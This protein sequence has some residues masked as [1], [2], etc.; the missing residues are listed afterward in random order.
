MIPIEKWVVKSLIYPKQLGF[1]L[2]LMTTWTLLYLFQGP[3]CLRCGCSWWS[4]VRMLSSDSFEHLG[5]N[6]SEKVAKSLYISQLTVLIGS[7]WWFQPNRKIWSSKSGFIFPQIRCEKNQI[8]ELPCH[9]ATWFLDG[10]RFERKTHLW[11]TTLWVYIH[12]TQQKGRNHHIKPCQRNP[13]RL[14]K[15]HKNQHGIFRQQKSWQ[16]F[17]SCVQICVGG[18]SLWTLQKKTC[19]IHNCYFHE[20]N[21]THEQWSNK[22]YVT[23]SGVLN[24]DPSNSNDLLYSIPIL[25]GF[26]TNPSEKISS[27]KMGSSSPKD[28]GEIVQNIIWVATT[29]IFPGGVPGNPPTCYRNRVAPTKLLLAAISLEDGFPPTNYSKSHG[30]GRPWMEGVWPPTTQKSL[31]GSE[32]HT[33]TNGAIFSH[34]NLPSSKGRSILSSPSIPPHAMNLL[35]WN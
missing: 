34:W 8:F 6:H 12:P 29:E 2:A 18:V 30:V 16:L 25:G 13:L 22:L 32:N 5:K 31:G 35:T 19:S 10:L 24:R 11:T 20:K 4:S 15:N 14:H 23:F 1:F 17:T 27:S 3:L 9:R 7:N 21:A 33:P 26:L 28:R